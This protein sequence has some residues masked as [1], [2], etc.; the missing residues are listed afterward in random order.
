MQGGAVPDLI[1]AVAAPGGYF[2]EILTDHQVGEQIGNNWSLLIAQLLVDEISRLAAVGDAGAADDDLL[3]PV[4]F[5][6]FTPAVIAIIVPGAVQTG[7]IE[8][9]REMIFCTPGKYI[10]PTIW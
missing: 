2:I 8:I 9:G 6:R 10:K 4:L 1:L 5:T 7:K 3:Q